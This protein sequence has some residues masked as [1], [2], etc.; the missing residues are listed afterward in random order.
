MRV[1]LSR[2][3]KICFENWKPDKTQAEELRAEIGD[4]ISQLM[5]GI[6]PEDYLSE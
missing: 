6:E 2:Q 5:E 1:A 4:E 3:A